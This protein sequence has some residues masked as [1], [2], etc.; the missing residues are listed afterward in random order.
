MTPFDACDTYT[1]SIQKL[2][3]PKSGSSKESAISSVYA[4]VGLHGFPGRITKSLLSLAA[5][6]S[7]CQQRAMAPPCL[8][9]GTP[10]IVQDCSLATTAMCH[11]GCR[12]KDS[13]D[14]WSVSTRVYHC[15][16]LQD[17]THRRA[18]KSPRSFSKSLALRSSCHAQMHLLHRLHLLNPPYF[19][20]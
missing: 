19:C 11:E 12:A 9:D 7:H 14:S 13:K 5:W 4:I 3:N 1:K 20:Q 15:C 17:P 16:I 6:T 10:H 2:S 18:M 8:A